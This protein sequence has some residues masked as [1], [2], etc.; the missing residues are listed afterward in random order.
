MDVDGQLNDCVAPVLMADTYELSLGAGG[1]Q[2]FALRAPSALGVFALCGSV[3]G[4]NPGTPIDGL[5]VPLD[6]DAYTLHTLTFPNQAPLTGSVG[7]FVPAG[8]GGAASAAFGLPPATSPG[9]T[10]LNLAHAFVVLGPAT[11]TVD[12]VSNAAPLVLLP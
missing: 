11:G 5:V 7:G 2:N 10:G 6:M 12:F 8:T 1:T 4:T 9:L 3:S